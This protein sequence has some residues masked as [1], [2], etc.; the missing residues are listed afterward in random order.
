M[1]RFFILMSSHNHGKNESFTIDLCLAMCLA[2]CYI[3][4]GREPNFL[5]SSYLEINLKIQNSIVY[6]VWGVGF[7]I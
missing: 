6:S 4:G 2:A 3:S 7:G 5:K 1:K